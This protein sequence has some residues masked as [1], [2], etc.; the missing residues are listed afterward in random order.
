MAIFRQKNIAI[1]DFFVEGIFEWEVN[2]KK[3]EAK[4]KKSLTP[5]KGEIL[6]SH[7]DE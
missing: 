5:K 7:P 6:K 4:Q 2:W 3:L 1:R